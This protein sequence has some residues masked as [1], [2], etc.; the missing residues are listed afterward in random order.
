MYTTIP[1]RRS[2]VNNIIHQ[3]KTDGSPLDGMSYIFQGDDGRIAVL[4]GGM[5]NDVDYLLQYLKRITGLDKPK[6]DLWMLSPA[7]LQIFKLN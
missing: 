4:D 6:V 3:L 1:R 7:G 5:K 2:N